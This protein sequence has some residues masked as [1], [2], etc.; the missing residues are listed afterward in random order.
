MST[1]TEAGT[2]IAPLDALRGFALGGIFVVNIGLMADPEG[3]GPGVVRDLV[4]DKA[5]A[6][7]MRSVAREVVAA[8]GD[9][10]RLWVSP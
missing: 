4:D 9:L 5:D 7:E 6:A 8:A 2:R 3:F 10:D 1:I